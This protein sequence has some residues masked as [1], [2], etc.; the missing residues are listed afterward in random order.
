[1]PSG[2]ARSHRPVVAVSLPEGST[3][4]PLSLSKSSEKIT[5]G[6]GVG[7]CSNR[8]WKLCTTTADH[9]LYSVIRTSSVGSSLLGKITFLLYIVLS[10]EQVRVLMRQ[11]HDEGISF[12]GFTVE[13][14]DFRLEI[15]RCS[16]GQPQLFCHDSDNLVLLKRLASQKGTGDDCN[17]HLA[18]RREFTRRGCR[19][20]LGSRG[21]NPACR[22]EAKLR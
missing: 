12:T 9:Y 20:W 6:S 2:S 5:P 21:L 15:G 19:R 8:A 13:H 18:A 1:V 11:V 22:F 3:S 4:Q 17:G 16:R 7:D 14:P 10:L